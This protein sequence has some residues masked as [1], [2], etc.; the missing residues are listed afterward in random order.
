MSRLICFPK[1][2]A[3]PKMRGLIPGFHIGR[4]V[5]TRFQ[6]RGFA[7]KAVCRAN[8]RLVSASHV[9]MISLRK[10][11]R[12]QGVIT[13]K[14]SLAHIT[15]THRSISGVALEFSCRA[16]VVQTQ[17]KRST[18]AAV[19]QTPLEQKLIRPLGDPYTRKIVPILRVIRPRLQNRR[20][21]HGRDA[22]NQ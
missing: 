3:N 16:S 7:T 6:S 18:R 22:Q 4:F 10:Y 19:L 20:E 1:G 8:G 11:F 9:E 17:S 21:S 12:R 14:V 13:N 2:G 5:L 15:N